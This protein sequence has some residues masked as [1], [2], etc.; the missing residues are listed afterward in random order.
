MSSD[1]LEGLDA[2]VAVVEAGGFAAAARRLAMTTSAVS[3]QVGRLEARLHARLLLRTTRRLALTE[4]GEVFLAHARRALA[5]Q[6]AGR[7]AV[8]E[9]GA[10]PRGELRLAAPMSFGILHIAPAI[11]PFLAAYPEMRVE[12]VLDDRVQDLVA[13]GFDLAI[14]IGALGGSGSV[15]ARRLA[16]ASGVL[17]ASPAYLARRG[18]PRAPA[19]LLEHETLLYAYGANPG[20]WRLDSP[21]GP[22]SVAVAPRL[23]SNNSLA[24][25]EAALAGAGVLRVPTF[26]VAADLHSGRLVRVLPEWRAPG[27]DVHAVFPERAYVPLK[28]RAFVEFLQARLGDPPYW[29]RSEQGPALR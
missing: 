13:G 11:A 29:E 23:T 4:A 1:S 9:L 6:A 28:A 2:F 16:S 8:I 19:D 21:A 27:L 22:A 5:E 20:E 10:A 25:R 15:V 18:T 24:L 17:C 12:M 26:V 3:K 7:E 14:R